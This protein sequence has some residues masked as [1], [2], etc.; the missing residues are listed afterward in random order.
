MDDPELLSFRGTFKLAS[1]PRGVARSA[2]LA[3]AEMVLVDTAAPLPAQHLS[4]LDDMLVVVAPAPLQ[5][6]LCLYLYI[7]HLHFCSDLADAL[8]A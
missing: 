3:A 4:V 7:T 8:Q 2:A 6:T 5:P 1:E